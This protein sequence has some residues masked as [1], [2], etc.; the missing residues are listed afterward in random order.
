MLFRE[1]YRSWRRRALFISHIKMN[2]S[3]RNKIDSKSE[4]GVVLAM[5][6]LCRSGVNALGADARELYWSGC[7]SLSV[8]A[9]YAAS[10]GPNTCDA[11]VSA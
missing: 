1:R 9:G 11:A 3:K 4:S 5:M 7:D 8:S 10:C 6:E 2:G